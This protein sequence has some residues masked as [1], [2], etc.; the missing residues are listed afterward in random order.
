MD[1]ALD[2]YEKMQKLAKEFVDAKLAV[3][4]GKPAAPMYRLTLNVQATDFESL[5]SRLDQFVRGDRTESEKAAIKERLLRL[6]IRNY[7]AIEE[8]AHHTGVRFSPEEAVAYMTYAID[9]MG[10]RK[11]GDK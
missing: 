6:F 11:G 3:L 4:D 5:S 1:Q 2:A 7:I 10:K 8:A 9:E